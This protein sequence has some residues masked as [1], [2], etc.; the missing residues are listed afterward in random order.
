MR[1]VEGVS[2]RDTF[3]INSKFLTCV[4]DIKNMEP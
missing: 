1:I 3:N 4:I 2:R